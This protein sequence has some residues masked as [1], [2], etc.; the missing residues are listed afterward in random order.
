MPSPPDDG[1][2]IRAVRP[3]RPSVR[4]FLR[5]SR[6]MIQYDTIRHIYVRSEA[7]GRAS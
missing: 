7:D 3:P 6:H 2:G 1:E 4:S 5:S